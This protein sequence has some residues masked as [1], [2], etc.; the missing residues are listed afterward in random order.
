MSSVAAL[1]S[2]G[3]LA[4]LLQ[5]FRNAFFSYMSSHRGRHFRPSQK[6]VTG[7]LSL[8]HDHIRAN[9]YA[10]ASRCTQIVRAVGSSCALTFKPLPQVLL[11]L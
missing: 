1:A 10:L 6:P 11:G 7:N 8:Y 3:K 5:S 4:A 2:L 9:Y